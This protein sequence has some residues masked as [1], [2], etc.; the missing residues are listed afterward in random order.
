MVSLGSSN[1]IVD[2]DLISA[3]WINVMVFMVLKELNE[4]VVNFMDFQIN[5]D[6]QEVVNQIVEE[7]VVVV[8]GNS[9]RFKHEIIEEG[10]A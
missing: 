10:K 5:V 4:E 8:M 1:V 2:E 6:K 7:E 9:I 3:N